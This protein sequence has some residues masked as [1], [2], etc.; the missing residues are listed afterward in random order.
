MRHDPDDRWEPEIETG[1]CSHCKKPCDIIGI[2]NGIGAYEFW[3]HKGR[4][5]QIDAV[6]DCCEEPVLD[7]DPAETSEI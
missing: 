5:V 4:D 6:S 3:G 1:W 7:M 2:D